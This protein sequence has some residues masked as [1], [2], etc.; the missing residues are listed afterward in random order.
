LETSAFD[1]PEGSLRKSV[2]RG[3]SFL[4]NVPPDRRGLLADSD[5]A[6]LAA[7][8]RAL[9]ATFD[10]NLAAGAKP[11]ASN[12]RRGVP[13]FSAANLLDGNPNT[14][15]ATDDDV[16]SADVV[17]ETPEPVTFNVVRVREAISL[18]QRIERIAVETWGDEDWKTVANATSIGSCRLLRLPSPVTASRVRLRVIESAASPALTGLSLH[19]ESR[20]G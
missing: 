4:L 5:V 14:Y 19:R 17:L 3:A 8:G 13:G 9:R 18:G 7:F 11:I 10:V 16:K 2:G 1:P 20:L 12:V 6:S 15:W